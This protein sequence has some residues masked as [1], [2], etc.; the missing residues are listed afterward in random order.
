MVDERGKSTN[1]KSKG[2]GLAGGKTQTK[3]MCFDSN[4]PST[5]LALTKYVRLIEFN[6]VS[7][8]TDTTISNGIFTR[9]IRRVIHFSFN[10]KRN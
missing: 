2:I 5:T 1:P 10:R 7:L 3:M 6:Y 8:F 4:E 9:I